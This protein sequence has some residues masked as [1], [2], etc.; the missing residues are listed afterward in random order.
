V[1]DD[2]DYWL[3]YD[4]WTFEQAAYLF[5]GQNPLIREKDP[6]SDLG[7]KRDIPFHEDIDNLNK[8]RL[9]Q[10]E[11]QVF[12]TYHIF[13]KVDW[14]NYVDMAAD[15]NFWYREAASPSAFI[16][17][18]KDKQIELP[19]KLLEKWENINSP[20]KKDEEIEKTESDTTPLSVFR[21]EDESSHTP[22]DQ[23][24]PIT[25]DPDSME[26]QGDKVEGGDTCDMYPPFGDGKKNTGREWREPS[27]QLSIYF[28]KKHSGPTKNDL[29]DYVLAELQARKWKGRGG[30]DISLDGVLKYGIDESLT[31]EPL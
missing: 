15:P 20:V 7:I 1:E 23:P 11:Q 13:R 25:E 16:S 19:P 28:Y 6:L 5:N 22:G 9:S 12:K 30:K 26:A 21:A 27:R 29:A 17:L 8:L 14:K 24:A 18:A 2:Y 4:E 3:M 31:F 10:T